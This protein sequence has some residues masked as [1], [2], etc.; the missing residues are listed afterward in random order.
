MFVRF[1]AVKQPNVKGFTAIHE[2]MRSFRV[3]LRPEWHDREQESC[4]TL[5]IQKI[6]Q[7]TVYYYYHHY[8][9]LLLLLLLL[10][11]LLSWFFLFFLDRRIYIWL[12]F[13]YLIFEIEKVTGLTICV[14]RIVPDPGRTVA[15]SE[16]WWIKKTMSNTFY[17]PF[18]GLIEFNWWKKKMRSSDSSGGF[19][20]DLYYFANKDQ[21]VQIIRPFPSFKSLTLK[22]RLSAKPI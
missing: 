17:F 18:S 20:L 16:T 3:G 12:F 22:T 7:S 9:L 6:P 10:L 2:T 8:L 15:P 5:Y 13:T 19:P 21:D 4:F 11:S 1:Y 14:V